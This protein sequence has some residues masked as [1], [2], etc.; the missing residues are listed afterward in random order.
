[1]AVPTGHARTV[2]SLAGEVDRVCCAN[3]RTGLSFAMADAYQNWYDVD[4]DE[5]AR[6]LEPPRACE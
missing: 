1:M 6:I 2:S 5:V 4:A 3:L